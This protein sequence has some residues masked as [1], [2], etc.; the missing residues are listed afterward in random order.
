MLEI[1]KVYLGDCI[2]IMPQIDNK[3]ID[4]ILC[5]LPYGTVQC[6]WDT[7]IP[8]KPLWEQYNRIIKDDGAIVLTSVQ[9]FTTKLISSNMDMFQ[10]CWVWDKINAANFMHA[11][12]HPLKSHEDICIFSKST[13]YSI[14]KNHVKYNPQGL[15]PLKNKIINNGLSAGG[16]SS[17]FKGDTCLFKNDTYKQ[18]FTGYPKTILTYPMD[19]EKLHPTQKP[20]SLF[21]YLIKTYT[22]KNDLV[23]DN[24][25]GSGTTGEACLKSGRNYILIEQD[26]KYFKNINKRLKNVEIDIDNYNKW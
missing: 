18:E 16:E 25:A 17:G 24:C 8:F 26:N 19:D 4:M 5:D 11:K 2:K 1:N 12:Y 22:N 20:V 21:K 23:L 15:I 7:I 3:S 14:S 13:S 9:P 6:S 10:Y